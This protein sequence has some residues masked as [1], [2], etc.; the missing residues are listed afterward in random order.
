MFLSSS[1]PA[2]A[3]FPASYSP[4]TPFHYSRVLHF[5]FSLLCFLYLHHQCFT[6]PLFLFLSLHLLAFGFTQTLVFHFL[7]S[8]LFSFTFLA[9]ITRTIPRFTLFSFASVV[10]CS[11]GVEAFHFGY[12]IFPC[13]LLLSGFESSSVCF[14]VLEW[15]G[16][17]ICS[18]LSFVMTVPP[19][20]FSFLVFIF[21]RSVAKLKLLLANPFD[22]SPGAVMRGK[23]PEALGLP[24][25]SQS[26]FLHLHSFLG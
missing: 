2:S 8:L 14:C 4:T 7:F 1:L 5:I 3:R 12:S 13:D 20:F 22:R 26:C 19:F 18:L 15:N 6:Y 21:S 11:G 25:V 16:V 17:S 9:P 23:P 24:H 10:W